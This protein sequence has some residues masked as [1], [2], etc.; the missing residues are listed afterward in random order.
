M[1]DNIVVSLGINNHKTD[2]NLAKID[3]IVSETIDSI[4]VSLL[5]Y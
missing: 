5:S 1:P 2:D 4:R 3:C